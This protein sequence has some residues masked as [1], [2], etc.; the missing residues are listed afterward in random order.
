MKVAPPLKL[1]LPKLS[2][3]LEIFFYQAFNKVDNARIKIDPNFAVYSLS[4]LSKHGRNISNI[5]NS[6]R[7]ESTRAD[8]G[9][10]KGTFES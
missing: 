5:R 9:V 8:L 7:S 10:V 1:F 6:S 4:L 3:D 2:K